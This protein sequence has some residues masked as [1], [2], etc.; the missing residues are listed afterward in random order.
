M[1]YQYAGRNSTQYQS[2][3]SGGSGGSGG[4]GFL[5]LLQVALIVLKLLGKIDWSWW[6][7][8]SPTWGGF[9]L[10]IAF[11]VG[12]VLFA[13]WMNGDFKKKKEK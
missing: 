6:L 3:N 8:W 1:Q 5:G 7:V 11:A 9:L 13:K 12:V 4:I 2:G 10:I